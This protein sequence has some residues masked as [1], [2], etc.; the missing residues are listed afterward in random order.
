MKIGL[1]L[2]LLGSIA[3]ASSLQ[4]GVSKTQGVWEL[5]Q[6]GAKAALF[7]SATAAEIDGKWFKSTACQK[8][9]V[10][11]GSFTDELGSGSRTRISYLSCGDAP[12]FLIE[13]RS[14]HDREFTSLAVRVVNTT[15]RTVYVSRI[16]LVDAAGTLLSNLGPP[17]KTRVLSDSYSEDTPVVRIYNLLD[18]QHSTHVAVGSQLIFNRQSGMSFFAGALTARRWLTVVH[19]N[20]GKFTIDNE[21]TTELTATK[22]LDPKRPAD[23]IELR[24]ALQPGQELASEELLLATGPRYL[25][26]LRAYGEAVRVA[27]HARIPE[28]APWGWWSWSAYYFGV[29]QGVALT[30]AEWMAAHLRDAGFRY[31]HLDEGYDY[32]RGEYTTPNK[33]NF[34]EG[35]ARFFRS[36]LSLGLTPGLWTAPFEISERSWVYRNHEDWLVKNRDGEPIYLGKEKGVDGIF[37]LDTT[38]PG[39]QEYLRKTYSTIA[40]DWGVRYIKLDFMESSAVEGVRYRQN[41]SALEAL[42]IG[43]EIIRDAVGDD[44]VLDKDGSPMLTPVGLVDAGRISNDTEHSFQGTFDAASGIAGRFFMNRNF[45]VA[46]P[47]A[48]CVSNYRSTDPEWDELKPV[49]FEEAKA[50]IVLSAM[51]GGMFEIGDDLPALGTEPE[52]LQLVTNNDLLKLMRLSRAAT[53]LDLMTFDPADLQPSIFWARES[54]RQGLLA[55]FNWT[56]EQKQR[57]ISLPEDLRPGKWKGSEIFGAMQV[58]IAAH[59]IRFEQPPHSVRVIKLTDENSPA[60]APEVSIAGVRSVRTGDTVTLEAK[61]VENGN[62]LIEYRWD[63]GDGTSGRGRTVRHTFTHPATFAVSVRA[64]SM[65]G[66]YATAKYT[67]SVTGQMD[68]SFRQ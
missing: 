25:E 58:S 34:P 50:A 38:N 30:N 5:S 55:V 44:V 40:H 54:K 51:A 29:S 43:L 67:V 46:D 2:G 18:P 13:A 45:F 17:E 16:R 65:D 28:Q 7:E 59:S 6:K 24:I 23:H 42:R 49:T 64:E 26:T 47:D 41:T 56:A 19:L 60:L 27:N 4:V 32:A 15:G 11:A 36:V 9:N 20:R 52:R 10:Q 22:S 14:Y 3:G 39:A 33:H 57:V 61:H 37:A 8:Q 66:P 63:F 1:L 68:T 35:M 12:Q 21:G 48:F 53:P 31:L 62:P